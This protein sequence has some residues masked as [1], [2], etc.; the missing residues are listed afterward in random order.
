MP[1]L[2]LWSQQFGGAAEDRGIT[3]AVDP[4]GNVVLS[5]FYRGTASFGGGNFTS[6]GQTDIFVAKYNASGSHLWSRSFGGISLDRPRVVATD[7]A[8]NVLL[9]GSF[10]STIDFGGGPLASSGSSDIFLVK[11]DPGGAHLWSKRFGGATAD[12]GLDVAVDATGS[13]ALAGSF[14]SGVD[15]GGGPLVS[16]GGFDVVVGRFDAS[17]AHQWSKH[18]GGTGT[19]EGVSV[20]IDGSGNVIL[21]AHFADNVDFGGGLL[22]SAGDLDIVLAKY[23]PGG[24]H[25]WSQRFGA[26]LGDEAAHVALDNAGNILMLG[27]FDGSVD[28]GGGPL[29][30]AGGLDIVLAKYDTSGGHLWSKRFGDLGPDIAQA[31]AVDGTGNV[32]VTGFFDDWID[33]GGGALTTVGPQTDAFVAKFDAG[34]TH[35]WSLGW[36]DSSSDAGSGVAIAGPAAVVTGFFGATVD[37]GGDPITSV[38]SVDVFLVKLEDPSIVPVLIRS[39]D[40]VPRPDG[41]E[42]TWHIFADEAVDRFTIYR[43]HGNAIA[44]IASGD[45]RATRSHLD[46]TAR[47]GESYHYELVIRTTDGD[48]FR[49]PRVAAA[50]PSHVAGL[51]RIFPNPF[52]PRTTIEYTVA[53]R[54]AI[55][56]EIFDATGTRVRVLNQGVREPGTYRSEWDGRDMYGQAA[57]SGLYFCRLAGMA[58]AG[59]GKMLLLK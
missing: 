34:G 6:A 9:T 56:I 5:G 57:S 51:G 13:I 4:G 15:L 47:P 25:Q 49:S 20:K 46:A 14:S 16:A 33:F 27:H 54:S 59:K 45:A 41:I 1:P 44:A 36:G 55:A 30:S 21:L 17:G 42:L 50:M 35:Q 23:N 12:H 40:A 18:F 37:F 22:A 29:A 32:T 19:D 7:G 53:S 8:G 3:V 11:L 28:F 2:H 48:E 43:G 58:G 52:N 24:V 26:A 10:Q 31:A 38:G 39:F